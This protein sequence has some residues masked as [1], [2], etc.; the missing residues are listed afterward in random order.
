MKT[1]IKNVKDLKVY[2]MA[3]KLAVEIFEM[4]KKFPKEET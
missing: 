1:S 4:T 3:Y 2:R